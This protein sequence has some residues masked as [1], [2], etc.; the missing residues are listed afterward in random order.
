MLGQMTTELK[1]GAV[2]SLQQ[3]Y[4]PENRAPSSLFGPE[5]EELILTDLVNI[6]GDTPVLPLYSS[7]SPPIVFLRP[8]THTHTRA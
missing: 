4:P 1:C 3:L 6:P 2:L 8:H 5:S 7:S